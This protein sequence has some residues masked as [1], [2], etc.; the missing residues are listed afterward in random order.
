MPEYVTKVRITL[1]FTGKDGSQADAAKRCRE[2]LTHL[3]ARINSG[4]Y[5]GDQWDLLAFSQGEPAC[6]APKELPSITV[7]GPNDNSA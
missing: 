4:G 7:G 6:A 2:E 5:Q 1:T 3:L